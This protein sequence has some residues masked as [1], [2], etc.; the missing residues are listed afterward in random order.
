[1]GP[2]YA[3][4]VGDDLVYDCTLIHDEGGGEGVDGGGAPFV[5]GGWLGWMD[6]GGEKR[7]QGYVP[8]VAEAVRDG[9]EFVVGEGVFIVAFPA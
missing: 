5:S 2:V 4:D 1:L 3:G 9:L 8:G 7:G 6:G